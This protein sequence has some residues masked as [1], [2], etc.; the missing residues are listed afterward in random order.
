M[1]PSVPQ[2]VPVLHVDIPLKNQEPHTNIVQLLSV[3]AHQ[4][5][6]SDMYFQCCCDNQMLSLPIPEYPGMF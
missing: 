2:P 6:D 3:A 4:A 1:Q 5:S